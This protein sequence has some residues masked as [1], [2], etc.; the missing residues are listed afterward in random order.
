MP[1]AAAAVV[2]AGSI[3]AA[4]KGSQAASKA[5]KASAEGADASA[6]V[7]QNMYDQSRSDQMP[8]LGTG[9]NALKKL[10]A[11]NG[12]QYAASNTP[13]GAMTRDNFDSGAY[14]AAHPEVGDPAQWNPDA[15][16]AYDHYMQYGRSNGFEFPYL[17][18]PGSATDGGGTVS[19]D[20]SAF[21]DSP[22]YKFT[23][24]QGQKAVNAGL[25]ARG[26]SGSGRAMKEL[27]KFGQGAASTQ[28]NQYRNALA[29]MAGV[30]QT[31]AANIGSQGMQAATNI[32]NSYQSSAD[33][34]ASGYLGSANA[35]NSAIQSGTSALAYMYGRKVA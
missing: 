33:A 5:S 18:A 15:H 21:Y 22:D 20:Y 29:A 9:N 6:Q 28:L 31:T 14:I 19:P 24:D 11:L 35:T 16:D 13:G 12:V 17:N 25:A 30:G 34:R 10:A 4:N 32:G 3:Y 1:L 23:F 2:A 8:W 7:Q 26:L 27:T